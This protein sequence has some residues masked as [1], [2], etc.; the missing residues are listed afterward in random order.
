MAI[1][2]ES[3]TPIEYLLRDAL[4]K[5]ELVFKEQHRIYTGGV[6]SEPKYVA[7]FYLNYNGIRLIV[8]CDG[9]SYHSGKEAIKKQKERDNWLKRKKY[10]VL[11]FSTNDLRQN[12]Y[13]VIQTIKHNLQMPADI[14]KVID[15]QKQ[16]TS[17]THTQHQETFE[18]LLFCYYRQALD[19]IYVVYKYKHVPSNTWSPERRKICYNVPCEMLE[20]VAF[21]MALLDIKRPVSIKVFFNGY[22]FNDNYDAIAKFKKNISLLNHSSEILKNRIFFKF[23]FQNEN[24]KFS[25][26]E[27]AKE[28]YHLKSR[29]RQLANKENS[30]DETNT[31]NYNDILKSFR[32]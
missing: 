18:V 12:M 28:L 1:L 21:Y 25:K 5:E 15:N 26:K 9:K 4:I 31:F 24:S 16:S 30:F 20:T 10:I 7:D 11:H 27:I 17:K 19:N 23:I 6:F 32:P 22:L 13:G 14:Q 29:A 3:S 8:E 2:F